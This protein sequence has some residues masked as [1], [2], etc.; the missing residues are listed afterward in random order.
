MDTAFDLECLWGIMEPILSPIV[1]P[2]TLVLHP[3]RELQELCS[4]HGYSLKWKFAKQEEV[5]VA[6]G[7]VHLEELI[8]AG[9]GS[10]ANKKAAKMAA[11]QQILLLMEVS[12]I[13]VACL[14]LS[15]LFT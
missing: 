11:A 14:N 2:E 15:L 9:T 8:I 5:T 4:Q 13:A 6:I 12:L 1:T 3:L 7:E 10:K